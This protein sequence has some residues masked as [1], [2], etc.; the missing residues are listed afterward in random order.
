[1]KNLA[2]Y[3]LTTP[4]K[5]NGLS[6]LQS[7]CILGNVEAVNV[8]LNYSPDKLDSAIALSIKTSHLASYFPGE[9]VVTVL[10]QLAQ[11]SPPHKLI[12]QLVENVVKKHDAASLLHLAAKTGNAQH[13]QR[14]LDNGG[15]VDLVSPE[16]ENGATPLMLAARFNVVDVVE[17]LVER[18][19]SLE[20]HDNQG[21]FPIHHAAFGGQARNIARL[22]A[23]GADVNV[24]KER[25]QWWSVS[26][27][28]SPIFLAAEYGHSEAV[29][30][31]LKHGADSNSPSRYGVTPLHIAATNGHLETTQLLLRNGGKLNSRDIEDFLPLHRAA[32]MGH[33]EVVKFIL[34]NGGSI[35]TKTGDGQTLLHLATCLELVSYLVQNGADVN[36][37]DH[38]RLTPLQVAAEKGQTDTVKYLL[39]QGA[40]I[41]SRDRFGCSALYDALKGGHTATADVLIKRGCELKLVNDECCTKSLIPPL[42][43][44]AASEGRTDQLDLL[45]QTG[46]SVN[47]TSISGE[48]ALSVAVRRGHCS[49]VA[50]LLDR[51]AIIDQDDTHENLPDDDKEENYDSCND[52]KRHLPLCWIMKLGQSGEYLPDFLIERGAFIIQ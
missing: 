8:I 16:T 28:L 40:N 7:A 17:F 2:F 49:T 22:I 48:T 37:R 10:G 19:A 45:F 36:A 14:L 12:N 30:V 3:A 13:L 18:G 47:T 51:G 9:P 23:Y 35:A 6:C 5:K 38:R 52:I 41:N 20:K 32:E 33:T 43:F 50:F 24:L 27:Q 26:D 29:D 44:K 11:E 25:E 31:M 15:D 46:I 34:H 4:D 39:S 1:M 42:L 21:Y